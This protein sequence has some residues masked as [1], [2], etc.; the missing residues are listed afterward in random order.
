MD[1]LAARW[2]EPLALMWAPRLIWFR[3]DR[4]APTVGARRSLSVRHGREV[5]SLSSEKVATEDSAANEHV[6]P[7]VAET[8]TAAVAQ[9]ETATAGWLRHRPR[10]ARLVDAVA[11]VVVKQSNYR[12][13]LSAAGAAFWLVIAIFPAAFAGIMI[14]GLVVSQEQIGNWLDRA[15]AASPNGLASVVAEQAQQVVQT[16]PSTLSLG[17][18]VSLALTLWSASAGAYALLRSLRLAYGLAPQSYV[19]ARARGV[20][21]TLIAVVGLGLLAWCALH[22]RRWATGL[23]G[24]ITAAVGVVI[25]L[26]L[27]ALLVTV[28]AATFR[29][30][31][32][33]PTPARCLMSGAVLTSLAMLLLVAGATLFGS[34]AAR[35]QATYGALTSVVV[36]LL[37]LYALMY[38]TLLAALFNAEWSPLPSTEVNA[39]GTPDK[40]WQ[41]LSG[42]LNHSAATAGVDPAGLPSSTPAA[43]GQPSQPHNK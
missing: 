1:I 37:A 34:Y 27:L 14:F 23:D 11:G 20:L 17:L 6:S 18:A 3:S 19:V 42:E 36:T 29:F 12:L 2:L 26:V 32:A 25:A 28:V 21:A 35:Y 24:W 13:S 41:R 8:L 16:E 5:R 31:I 38:A 39:A 43:E 40:A 15:S 9:A 10:L 4:L 33:M 30:A 7:S 22:I